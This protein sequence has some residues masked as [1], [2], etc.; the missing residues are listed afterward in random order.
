MRYLVLSFLTALAFGVAAQVNQTDS[1]GRKQGKWE[2]KYPKMTTY[3]YQGQFK[4]DKPVGTFTYYYPTGKVKTIVKHQP[5]GRSTAVM[6]HESGVVFATGIYRNQLKDSVWDYFGPS[7]RQSLKETYSKGKLHGKTTVYYVP[8]D[9]NDKRLLPARVTTYVNGVIEGDVIEYF[10]G[11][12]VKSSVKYVAGDRNGL[13]VL[14]HPNGKPMIQER[15][16]NGVRHGWCM[17]FDPNGKEIGR[18]YFYYGKELEGKELELK[19]K[20]FKDK[21]INPNG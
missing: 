18:K 4:D 15:Y 8:E 9:I 7:G 6:Y 1:K 5:S 19:M 13:Y 14:N 11:G 3:E 12:G 17:T 10:E 20:E 16:K 2:K 21:G